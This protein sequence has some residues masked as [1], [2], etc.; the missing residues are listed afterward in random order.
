LR[1]A[2]RGLRLIDPAQPTLLRCRAPLV[3]LVPLVVR[4]V[5]AGW[6]AAVRRITDRNAGLQGH[7]ARPLHL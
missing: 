3:P 5:A 2:L 6:Q 7:N 4:I 1:R